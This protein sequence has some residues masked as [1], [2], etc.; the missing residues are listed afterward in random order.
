M[1]RVEQLFQTT[2]ARSGSVL[3]PFMTAGLPDPTRSVAVFEAMASAGADGFEVGIPYADPLMALDV[4]AAVAALGKPVLAM[5]YANPVFRRGVEWFC[6]RLAEAGADGIIVPDL[7]VEESGS[8]RAAAARHGI[9]VVQ[10]VAPTSDEER[11]AAAVATDPLFV[12]AVAEMGVTGE[13]SQGSTSL[14]P[15]IE[16]IRAV[17]SVPVVCGV[18]ISTPE[19]AAAAAA[20]GADGV[21]VGSALVRRVL[22]ESDFDQAKEAVSAAVAALAGALAG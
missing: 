11:V 8:L 9:G 13:R 6:L 3:L 12:Y 10:F 16:R 5:T 1:N 2:R 15:L 20:L 14:G 22:E 21:I 7:P 17:S 18:G 19:Q 4:V